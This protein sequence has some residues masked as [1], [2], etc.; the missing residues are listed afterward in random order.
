[1]LTGN[2]SGKSPI[3][4]RGL[5]VVIASACMIL[6]AGCGANSTVGRTAVT[7]NQATGGTIHGIVHGGRQPIAG[8]TVT[9][10]EVGNSGYGS[11]GGSLAT[12][13]TLSD[14]T[15]NFQ[16]GGVSSYSCPGSGSGLLTSPRRVESRPPVAPTTHTQI[17]SWGSALCRGARQPTHSDH[18]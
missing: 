16:P 8:A 9:I 17:W 4:I 13:T 10:W 18:Q 15:F 7:N 11:S 6:A 1:M 5:V 14:G 12:T 3:L 2:F